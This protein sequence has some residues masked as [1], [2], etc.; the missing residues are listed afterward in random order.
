VHFEDQLGAEKKCGHMGGKVLIPTRQ[1]VKHL[2]AARLAADVCGVPLVIVARTDAESARLLTSDID[3]RDHEFIDHAAGR[4]VEGFFRLKD[5]GLNHSIK[6][7]L[8]FAPYSD[9]IWMETSVPD[10]QQAKAF[11]E[12]V[13][14]VFPDKMLAYNCSPSFNWRAKLDPALL[15]QFQK[16][17]GAMG[18]KFQFVTLAGF[19]ANNYGMFELARNYKQSGME[20][21]SNL[22]EKEFAAEKHGYTAVKHQRE[23]GAGYFDKVANTAAGGEVSTQALEGS[24]EQAQFYEKA[25][26]DTLRAKVPPS[27]TVEPPRRQMRAYSTHASEHHAAVKAPLYNHLFI[28]YFASKEPRL[29]PGAPLVDDLSQ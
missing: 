12:G 14:K 22:Q 11:A 25:V 13:K 9:L 24:T 23:V 8:A 5:D 6:R 3:E 19:H 28:E 7:A 15:P 18:F 17:L 26:E 29:A 2:N 4:T 20:A 21:Y 27:S 10:I 1:H 16:E